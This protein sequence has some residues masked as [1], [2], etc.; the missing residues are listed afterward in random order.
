MLNTAKYDRSFYL[1]RRLFVEHIRQHV[2]KLILA[3][4]CMILI[5]LTTAVN[6]W[7]MK[8]VLDD[9]FLNKKETTL[10][11]I[12]AVVLLNSIIKG[13]A[14]FYESAFMK[15]I[16]QKIVTDIQLRLYSHLIYADTKFLTEYPSGN[17]ISRMTNDI[18]A[19]RRSVSDVLTGIAKEFITLIGLIGIM[20][21]Q[22][23]DLT[24]I[25]LF[26]FPLAFYP[27]IRLGK[28]M[29]KVAKD[30][31]EELSG[32]TVRLDETFQNTIIIKSYCREK[33]E[34]SMAKKI[35]ERF[36]MLYKK[37]AYIESASS[38]IMET[39]GGVAIALVIWYGGKQ[40]I[41]G[42][43]TPGAFFS[44]ITALL[45]S[46]RPLKIVSQLN[47]SLQEGLSAS[48][49]LFVMLDEKPQIVDDTSKPQ[50]RFTN[51]DIKFSNVHFSYKTG[52]KILDGIN[53]FIPQGKTVALV[54]GSGVGKTTVLHILQR[55]YDGDEGCVTIGDKDITKIRLKSL[56]ESIAFVSQETTLFD[57]TIA[58]NIRY[59]NLQASHEQIVDASLAA[60]AHDFIINLPDGYNTE[61]GQNG[62]KL[63]GGQRQR[64]AIA[65][66]ILKNAPILLLDE[67]TSALDSISEKQVQMALEYLKKGRTTIVIAHRLSTVESADIIYFLLDGKVAEFGDHQE[68]LNKGSE[69]A[70]LYTQYKNNG[71]I[72]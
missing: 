67:A 33:Y 60:A 3:A 9:I 52:Q 69:Y 12:P 61:I 8:P 48:K 66:A 72:L 65:R 5:S 70:K 56:R 68:L 42:S 57:E 27:I 39:L 47:T 50:A 16:G 34:I 59:G 55:L 31:Q 6:A 45:M 49:R 41:D 71:T 13:F 25:A 26:I 7:L 14:S 24:I 43:T 51:F 20:F 11:I 22:S 23:F 19:M 37:A 10:Y 21:Y 53:L 35:M 30:M 36:L 1:L 32:F 29:R 54:G 28:R 46:Y 58:E 17:L 63:S 38:P 44:F 64:L 15:R 62:V 2:P 4:L 40:V 18:N